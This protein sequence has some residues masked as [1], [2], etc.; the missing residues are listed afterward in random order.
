MGLLW[1]TL[2]SRADLSG[3]KVSLLPMPP[4]NE[5]WLELMGKVV[6][7]GMV[8]AIS[9]AICDSDAMTVPEAG[10][11]A[12]GMMSTG[13]RTGLYSWRHGRCIGQRQ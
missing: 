1:L 11:K 3:G 6:A 9:L 4:E 8:F 2:K 7:G 13:R 5:E 10:G 12:V